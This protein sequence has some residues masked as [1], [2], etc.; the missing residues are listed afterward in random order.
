VTEY[1]ITRAALRA[2]RDQVIEILSDQFAQ[3][4]LDV[5]EFEERVD[6]AHRA[7]DL[8]GLDA[9][10]AD[11][12]PA[13]A[14]QAM[15]RPEPSGDALAPAERSSEALTPAERPSEALTMTRPAR[16]SVVSV[17]GSAKR[18]GQW[19]VPETLKV[20]SVLGSAEL[21]LR[22]ALLPPGITDVVVYGVL[23]EVRVIVPPGLAIESD[24]VG[25]L[26]DITN[27]DRAPRVEDPDA[28]L[29]R[30]SGVSVLSELEIETRLPGESRRDA[31]RRR[32]RQRR[33]A[34]KRR[35]ELKA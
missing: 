26:A 20:V 15:I 28:P 4:H 9:L 35:R 7:I 34:R 25:I 21:D 12:E 3:D 14:R 27:I 32:R 30:I 23:S 31:K 5:D 33:L 29:V 1:Q 13:P 10:V 16:K 2:R 11:L 17:L 8:E 24:G 6:R 22:E 19:R 18:H